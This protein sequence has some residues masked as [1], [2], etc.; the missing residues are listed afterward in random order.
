MAKY[1][2]KGSGAGVLIGV[3]IMILIIVA[4]PAS[5]GLQ[6]TGI[7]VK[8]DIAPGDAFE[9]QITVTNTDQNNTMDVG[10]DLY[11]LGQSLDGANIHLNPEEDT[12][13]YSAESFLNLS[14]STVHLEP[15][16][17]QNVY[18]RGRI[19]S[20]LGDGVRYAVIDIHEVKPSTASGTVTSLV[21]IDG[22]ILLNNTKSVQWIKTG[23]ITELNVTLPK[24]S[25]IFNNT[26]NTHYSP[27][28]TA[29]LKDSSGKIV[30][31]A[32]VPTSGSAIIPTYARKIDLSFNLKDKLS[33]G[34]Y[35]LK[36]MAKL[37][38]GGALDSR[39]ITV[40]AVNV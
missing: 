6:A 35:T 8:R 17:S 20:D 19:P 2:R 38:D 18:I 21:G 40:N 11:G 37:A 27:I 28:I 34:S 31:S 13:P 4:Y 23:K 22:P 33:P 5:A 29:T 10:F 16:Q 26:G 39:E 25:L 24:V 36:V 7:M 1:A 9:H 12:S 14:N 32:M 3:L 15:G 30:S